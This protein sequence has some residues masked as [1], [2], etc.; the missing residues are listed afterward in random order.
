MSKT[1]DIA[2]SAAT[3]NYIDG[4]T[5]DAQTQLDGK[6]TL[7]AQAVASGALANGDLVVINADG[8]VSVVAETVGPPEVGTPSVFESASSAFI[9][10]TFDSNSNKVVIA[11]QDSANS[12]YGTAIVGTVSGTSISFGSPV[13]FQS[14]NSSYIG[15]TFDT[16]SNKV[17][18]A[19]RNGGNSNYGTAIVGTVSGTSISFGSSV[20]FESASSYY[21]STTFDTNSNKVVIAYMDFANSY[22]GT[23]VVGTVSGTSISFGTPVVFQTAQSNWISAT[24]DNNSNNVVIA[25]ENGGNSSYGTAVVGTVS[26][27]SIS[28]GTPVVFESANA[29]WIGTTFNSSSNKVVIAYRNGGNS[30]YGT[31]IVG[32]VSGT[33]ISF[34]SSVVFEAASISETF[35]S[36]DSTSNV[37]LIAYA[38]NGDS[39]ISKIV[40]GTVSGTSISFAD[41]VSLGTT[42]TAISSA[43][44]S[45]S[46]KVVISYRDNGNSGFG[47][48]I[49]ASTTTTQNLTAENYIGISDA[50]YT[51]GATANIQVS[52]AVDDA[53]SGLTAG[54]AYYVQLDG[55]LSTT[56]DN[57]SVF[58]GTALSATELLIGKSPA[59]SLG[60]LGVTATATELN[61]VSGVTSA[62]QTQIDGVLPA[63]TGNAGNFLTTDGTDASWAGVSASPTLE[64]VASGSLA[65]G[66]TVIVNA[67]GTVS[68]AGLTE[69]YSPNVGTST[70]F[71]SG[72]TSYTAPAFDSNSNKIVIAYQDSSNS[73]YGTAVVGTVSGTTISFGTPVVFAS[74]GAFFPSTT[75]DSNSNKV[76]IAYSDETFP[77]KGR[78]IVGTVS[79]TTISFGSP[80]AF[81]AEQISFTNIVFD[82]NSNKVVV[83]YLQNSDQSSRAVVG[84]VSG[85]SI[86]FGSEVAFGFA[87]YGAGF[88]TATFDSNLNKVVVAYR[89]YA[90][91]NG[92]SRVGT[93]SG[94]SISF[95]SIAEF[96]DRRVDSI[97]ITFDSNSNKV[98]ISYKDY[99]NSQYGTAIVGTVSGTS[100][101]FGTS[102]VFRSIDISNNPTVPVFDSN[103]NKIALTYQAGNVQTVVGTVSGTSISFANDIYNPSGPN[104]YI[105]AT[106]DSNANKVVITSVITQGKAVVYSM[107]GQIT[108]LTTENYI[109]ISD[110]A[111][112]DSAT[113]TVQIVGSVD[114]AQSGLTAGQSYYVQNDGSLGTTADDPSVFAGTAVSTTKL[115]V[116]G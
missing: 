16:N 55:T 23:A 101:S 17:V 102:V 105:N 110:G 81:S 34:G 59:V 86:S 104:A 85:T 30:L 68:V 8:T 115:I 46:D 31:A 87:Q 99:N 47:T 12:N 72:N 2:D 80:T 76:V 93:V 114:D 74:V 71:E 39:S 11:Y 3:I 27:T 5:S 45:S 1:R 82:S 98:V 111:Y 65:N 92:Y 20:V 22:Y 4:L 9:S 48:S 42:S 97:G 62:I 109:G 24:F 50:A 70:Q 73:E 89:N 67:D 108:N 40:A 94:T 10:A 88:L 91:S 84:T 51:D 96:L 21:M 90:N 19:Y 106:F 56:P 103:L 49:V 79:G 78:A 63:Q 95:G 43:F 100:I 29:T 69:A 53:Q 36:Y 38:D 113:A 75:F 66:D 26:G 52:G 14:G 77:R 15:T 44:D 107:T 28:F 41:T 25:Y 60:E 61:Y 116:K 64:A 37:V 112:S 58:A 57:P 83:V 7:D 18:I 32:T 54:E 13:V 35:A 6:A 33:S